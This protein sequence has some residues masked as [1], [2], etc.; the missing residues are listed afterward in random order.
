MKKTLVAMIILAAGL[1]LFA[2]C[3]FDSAMTEGASDDGE[4][5]T[6]PPGGENLNPG[7]NEG[8]END[9]GEKDDTA[10]AEDGDEGESGDD[11]EEDTEG[12]DREENIVSE[13]FEQYARILSD[14]DGLDKNA[15]PDFT[16]TLSNLVGADGPNA[17]PLILKSEAPSPTDTSAQEGTTIEGM[18]ASGAL[19]SSQ[20]DTPVSK[21]GIVELLT[22][23]IVRSGT[24][25]KVTIQFC[26][27]KGFDK[28]CSKEIVLDHPKSDDREKGDRDIYLFYDKI[29][30]SHRY[31][32]IS[33]TGGGKKGEWLLWG[34]KVGVFFEDKTQNYYT[35]PCLTKWIGKGDSLKFGPNDTAVCTIVQTGEDSTKDSISLLVASNAKNEKEI[36]FTDGS[37]W[38][39]YGPTLKLAYEGSTVHRDNYI[40]MNLHWE[41]IDKTQGNIY[42]FAFPY[43]L[44]TYG[45]YIFDSNPFG[46]DKGLVKIK[47][48]G[49]DNWQMAGAEVFI[50]NP[51]R[52]ISEGY[53]VRYASMKPRE[54]N[55]N[56]TTYEKNT[57][58]VA[59]DLLMTAHQLMAVSFIYDYVDP[60]GGHLYFPVKSK[61]IYTDELLDMFL[62]RVSEQN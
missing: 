59:Y 21:G 25:C 23:P 36:E 26:P 51:A 45:N 53:E 7:G 29:P 4:I 57:E 20:T 9:D 40:E 52:I 16:G 14:K 38:S 33:V 47:K 42:N 15:D 58:L 10:E 13:N 24:D 54:F 39:K 34:I 5:V 32:K 44:F 50:F 37:K 46:D 41:S 49:T 43:Q 56:N 22:G 18:I 35:N 28:N 2:S 55:N 6:P 1:F 3:N 60:Y 8:E 48:Y 62:R 61:N 19:T 17:H 12:D 11:G 31:F 27:D 30:A